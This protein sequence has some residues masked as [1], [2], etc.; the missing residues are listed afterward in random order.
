MKFVLLVLTFAFS[1]VLY[2]SEG[3]QP[4][5][6]EKLGEV[7]PL[8]R[9]FF[10]DEKGETKSLKDFGEGKPI[11]LAL[12]FFLCRS[13]CTP[14][15]N[16]VGDYVDERRGTLNPGEDFKLLT[17]S[18]DSSEDHDMAK[19]KK[20]NQFVA[21][22]NVR[23]EDT[24]SFLT[25]TEENIV[26][27][28][29]AVGFEYVKRPDGEILHQ[30]ALIVLSPE[31]KVVRY[32]PGS[33]R[34]GKDTHFNAMSVDIAVSEAYRGIS[35]PTFSKIL[36]VCFKF[37]PV[38]KQYT[39]KVLQIFGLVVT[40]CAVFLFLSVTVLAKKRPEDIIESK[41]KEGSE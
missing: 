15:I 18:F 34:E 40:L 2:C 38:N 37:D 24:W 22:K 27:L 25:G 39:F 1:S 12:S 35:G 29:D 7:V 14:F 16:G 32:L 33:W 20:Y 41:E 17:I 10:I 23:S 21:M 8:E 26:A 31:G 13:I 19:D 28:T 9:L 5:I 11:V 6:V 36:N 4:R 3:K 30:S